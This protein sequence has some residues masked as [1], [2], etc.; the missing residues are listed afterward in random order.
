MTKKSEKSKNFTIQLN[1]RLTGKLTQLLTRINE[2]YV[3]HTQRCSLTDN[4]QILVS[5]YI[6]LLYIPLRSGHR[7]STD[8]LTSY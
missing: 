4:S 7:W 8:K 6:F 3:T 1:F 5:I 2:I